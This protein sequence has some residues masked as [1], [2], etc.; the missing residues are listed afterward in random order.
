[1]KASLTFFH[2]FCASLTARK[3]YIFRFLSTGDSYRTIAFS[4]RV[5]NTTVASIVNE[6]CDA[7]WKNLQPIF[8]PRPNIHHWQRSEEGFRVRWDFPNCIGAVDGKHVLITAPPNSGTLFF[9]YKK[10]Y[11]IVLMALVDPQYRFTVVDIGSYGSNSDG[12]IFNRSLFGLKL[13]DGTLDIPQD[14]PLHGMEEDGPVPHVIVGDEAFPLSRNVMR[15]FPGKQLDAEARIFNYR[16]SRARRIS[17][18][19]FGILANRW[20]VYHRKMPLSPNNVDKVVK[21]TCVLHNMLQGMNTPVP[22]HRPRDEEE[23][24]GDIH[25]GILREVERGGNHGAR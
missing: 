6:T 21:A 5:G 10:T 3:K 8:M 1:M 2:L 9:N 17:E 4:Y 18:N 11:S 7:I 12:G 22:E 13:A 25:D 14:K 20:R 24:E 23:R 19:A 16:L 15:P